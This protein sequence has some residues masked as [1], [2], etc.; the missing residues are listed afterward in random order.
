M[1]YFSPQFLLNTFF[2]LN[3]Y[4]EYADFLIYLLFVLINQFLLY[5]NY[6]N[7]KSSAYELG[8][9]KSIDPFMT[10]SFLSLPVIPSLRITTKGVF[11]AENWKML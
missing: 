10:L 2:D 4:N 3:N 8:A 11:D 5:S 9:D 1:T 6:T 7:A